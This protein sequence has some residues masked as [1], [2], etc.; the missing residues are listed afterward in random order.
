[1][2]KTKASL[3]VSCETVFR[4]S[5]APNSFHIPFLILLLSFGAVACDVSGLTDAI[6]DFKI[7]I[8]LED[9]DTNATLQVV[10]AASGEL[11]MEEVTVR[12]GG[13][14]GGDVVDLYSDPQ[15]ELTMENGLATFGLKNS[16]S[17]T[18][19]NP[20]SVTLMISGE[21][22]LE[23][24]VDVK[25]PSKGSTLA[26]ARLVSKTS[27]PSNVSVSGGVV[28]STG[29]GGA[30]SNALE[31]TIEN[32]SGGSGVAA[33]VSMPGGTRLLA[34]DGSPLSGTLRAD[35]VIENALDPSASRSGLGLPITHDGK[36]MVPLAVMSLSITDAA[37]RKA[38]SATAA[39][40]GLANHANA[41]AGVVETD[42]A[43]ACFTVPA[44]VYEA[45][46][47]DVA[48]FF[49]CDESKTCRLQSPVG[50][51]VVEGGVATVCLGLD[52]IPTWVGY[53]SSDAVA[54]DL[55]LAINR[56]GNNSAFELLLNDASNTFSAYVPSGVSSVV[57]ENVSSGP[58]S[59]LAALPQGVFV[60]NA[61]PVC[62]SGSSTLDLPSASGVIDSRITVDL[63]CGTV[64]GQRQYASV[65]NLPSA[66][67]L[68]R[69]S[70]SAQG[71]G[72][73]MAS[74]PEWNYV[75]GEGLEGG[76]FTAWSV[77]TGQLYDFQVVYD[78]EIQ[79]KNGVTIQGPA[80]T[81]TFDISSSDFCE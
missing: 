28:G 9:I 69:S 49:T 5:G 54:C 30:L 59:L 79:R 74:S 63:D 42:G 61:G 48:P 46:K 33:A 6:D 75:T 18:P 53:G 77:K 16:V 31:L 36:R 27:P 35:L 70:A 19:S 29:G 47:N 81:Y 23:Q 2:M 8:G 26:V 52:S 51:P 44:S 45:I 13:R 43:K 25:M 15:T 3:P 20:A 72:W 32:V 39:A 7:I 22:Y 34:A 12:F 14:N 78:G 17:P 62:P 55:T 57:F 65:N 58:V 24:S 40:K 71:A 56:N 73:S 38:S 10:D 21:G 1:M 60:S 11:I 66:A 80:F 64:N 68:Y 4:G 41:L 76:S 67:I 37:G 50:E